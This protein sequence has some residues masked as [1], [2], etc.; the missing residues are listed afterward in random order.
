MQ[1]P[2]YSPDL[3]I[4]DFFMFPKLKRPKKGRRYATI[5][6]LNTA[7]KEELNKITKNDFLKGFKDWKKPWHKCIISGGHY[8]EGNKIDIH[9]EI[10]NF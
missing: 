5:E 3:A 4:R 10:N 8:F 2:P 6:E 1:Q 7:S 9:E